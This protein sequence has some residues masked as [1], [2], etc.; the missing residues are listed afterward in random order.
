[1]SALAANGRR[2]AAPAALKRRSVL[3]V[4]LAMMLPLVSGRL[5]PPGR[6]RIQVKDGLEEAA[7]A[8][9]WKRKRRIG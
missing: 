3:Q 5:K 6:S 1:M 7:L 9:A 2:A 4:L 8:A